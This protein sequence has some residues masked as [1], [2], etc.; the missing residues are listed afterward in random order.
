[1]AAFE[2]TGRSQCKCELPTNRNLKA[3]PRRNETASPPN[4]D[5]WSTCRKPETKVKAKAHSA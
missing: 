1:M 5:S 3:P 4:G 2:L